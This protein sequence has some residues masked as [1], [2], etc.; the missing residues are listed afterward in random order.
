MSPRNVLLEPRTGQLVLC[1]QPHAFRTHRKWLAH[2]G[3]RIDLHD[4][5]FSPSRRRDWSAP[6][7]WRGVLAYC[8]GDRTVARAVWRGQRGN[9]CEPQTWRRDWC[10][11][12]AALFG[13]RRPR[14]GS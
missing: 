3:A 4:A 1:D 12:G 5:F 13:C 9:R 14:A 6:E 2:D 10:R 8:G 11:L 7:R